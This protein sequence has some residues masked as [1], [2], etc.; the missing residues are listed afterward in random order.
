[1]EHSTHSP[2]RADPSRRG[3]N[4]VDRIGGGSGFTLVELLVVIGIIAVLV[5][6]LLPALNRARDSARDVT[7]KS[8]IRQIYIGLVMYGNENDQYLPDAW[9]IIERQWVA[10]DSPIFLHNRLEPHVR[11]RDKVWFCPG[12]PEGSNPYP[13]LNVVGTPDDPNAGT[14]LGTPENLGESYYYIAWAWTYWWGPAEQHRLS[15]KVRFSKPR[16]PDRAKV[17]ACVTPQQAPSF[18]MVGPHKNGR[19]WN[20]L[21]LDGS[22]TS[23]RGMFANPPE[24]DNL[25]NFAGDWN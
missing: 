25:V 23:T 14:M 2:D 11:A 4:R 5:A 7:C 16:H 15:G 22:I 3:F 20:I 17:M 24:N 18:G 10:W 9:Y 6:M 8:N 1:M 13:Y 19:S 21:W 12:W